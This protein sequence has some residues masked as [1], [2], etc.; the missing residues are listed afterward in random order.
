MTGVSDVKNFS[1][2]AKKH[3]TSKAHL[4]CPMK[5]AMLGQVNIAAQLD[6]GYHVSVR[7]HSKEVDNNRH[8]LSKFIDC[9][10]LCG[11]FELALKRR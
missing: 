4:H 7:N 1:E 11:A 6:E 2:R 10:Q 3:E 9:V 8:F 5:L